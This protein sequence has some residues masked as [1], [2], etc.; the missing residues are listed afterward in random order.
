MLYSKCLDKFHV[1]LLNGISKIGCTSIPPT[2]Q[3]TGKARDRIIGYIE[4][5]PDKASTTAS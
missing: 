1:G 3:L 2:P 5:D 4:Q